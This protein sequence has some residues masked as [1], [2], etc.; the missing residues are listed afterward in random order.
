MFILY[1]WVDKRV[2]TSAIKESKGNCGVQVCNLGDN[3]QM[4]EDI[5]SSKS[6]T[7]IRKILLDVLSKA[8]NH[9]FTH[10]SESK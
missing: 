6:G 9:G 3:K 1:E 2:Y 4:Q 10:S 7:E 8:D 5:G